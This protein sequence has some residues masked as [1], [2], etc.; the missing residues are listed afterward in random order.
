MIIINTK[1]QGLKIIK[2]KLNIDNRGSLRETFKKKIINWEN[3]VCEYFTA[4]KKNVIRGLHFQ[5]KNQ[6]AKFI[7]VA[8]GKILD[9][10]IDLRKKSKTFGK[11]FSIILSDKN[12]KSLYIPKGFAHGF[13]CYDNLNIMHYK[14]SDYYKPG[15]EGGIMWNDKS[16]KIKWP[17]KKPILSKKDSC[18]LNFQEFLT[19]YKSL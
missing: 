7:T 14:L 16:L 4:S 19:K 11:S 12:C 8:K 18:N 6:Q 3:F 10:V 1:I 17:T 9:V 13:Y 2:H 5:Y 15:S